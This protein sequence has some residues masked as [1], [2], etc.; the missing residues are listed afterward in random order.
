MSQYGGFGR[1]GSGQWSHDLSRR[2]A[3][4]ACRADPPLCPAVTRG[5]PNFAETIARPLR[6]QPD[7]NGFVIVNGKE[8]FNRPLYGLNTAFRVDAGDLPE[9]S[10]YLPGRWRQS[11]DGL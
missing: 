10:L 2:F 5:E 8:T 4:R 11:A 9:L 7:G 6:Y 3:D 1:R